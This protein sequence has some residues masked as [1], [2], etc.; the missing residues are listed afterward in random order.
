MRVPFFLIITFV[1][2]MECPFRIM[3]EYDVFLDE[4]SR[5]LT[6]NTL[7]EYSKEVSQ[8]RKQL[9]IITPHTL[10][11]ITTS[12]DVRIQKMRPPE[13]SGSRGVQQTTID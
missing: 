3:D 12:S 11:G 9:V 7:L 5:R 2:Q 8:A 4:L 6:L 1:M 10:N 13:R